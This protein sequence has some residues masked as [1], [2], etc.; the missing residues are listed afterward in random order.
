MLCLSYCGVKPLLVLHVFEVELATLWMIAKPLCLVGGKPIVV[1]WQRYDI[2]EI[3]FRI[4]LQPRVRIAFQHNKF[5]CMY[6]VDS[7]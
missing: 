6:I 5:A 4:F 3:E 7:L 2:A 1:E